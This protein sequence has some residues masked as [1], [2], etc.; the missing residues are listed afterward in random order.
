MSSF[1][2]D[3]KGGHGWKLD[4]VKPAFKVLM[5]CLQKPL[6]KKLWLMLPD[7]ICLTSS[8]TQNLPTTVVTRQKHA[9]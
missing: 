6:K 1:A 5:P 9:S 8:S 7:E 2:R 3:G 4:K